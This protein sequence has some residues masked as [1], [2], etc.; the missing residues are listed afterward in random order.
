MADDDGAATGTLG[1][2]IATLS[3]VCEAEAPLRFTDILERSGQPR[4][5]LHR[6]L[7]HLVA[8]G[9]LDIGRD[10]LYAPGLRLLSLAASAWSRNEMRRLAEP[11][12]QALN[13]LTGE[14]VHLGVL[15]GSEIVY[16]DK[17]EGRQA[18]RMYSQIGRASPVYCTGLLHRHRQGGVVGS[19]SAG[20]RRAAGTP[21]PAAVY[22]KHPYRS[23][24]AC[25]GDRGDCA[26]WI[27]FRP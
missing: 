18:I 4:G 13:A 10:Q 11:H 20:A 19:G 21:R 5:T 12:L 17:V 9:L 23:R 15:R 25:A 24:R 8:E 3:L 26:K 14:T 2:A 22:A 7:T 6:Q 27:R 16:L 1:K